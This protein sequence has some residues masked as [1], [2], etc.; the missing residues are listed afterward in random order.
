MG[1]F[2]GGFFDGAGSIDLC[3]RL[4]ARYC[5]VQVR[6]GATCCCGMLAGD[7]PPSPL[8]LLSNHVPQQAL[9]PIR[10]RWLLALPH[11]LPAATAAARA[12]S[13]SRVHFSPAAD[14]RLT[15]CHQLQWLSATPTAATF[16]ASPVLQYTRT[17]VCVP[18]LAVGQG[19]AI[20]SASRVYIISHIC[21]VL[22]LSRGPARGLGYQGSVLTDFWPA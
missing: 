15:V 22:L 13:E 16:R 6:A 7:R 8:L 18:C 9:Q 2:L 5:S 19:F 11:E 10:P 21:A 14:S 17:R 1:A 20:A 4:R 3:N 12:R